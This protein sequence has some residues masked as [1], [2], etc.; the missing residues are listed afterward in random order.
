MLHYPYNYPDRSCEFKLVGLGVQAFLGVSPEETYSTPGVR[1]LSIKARGCIFKNE[2][3]PR[4][5][6]TMKNNYTWVKYSYLNCL[7]ECRANTVVEKCGCVP[8]YVPQTC[9]LIFL[10][11]YF[12][13][14]SCRLRF[15]CDLI[16]SAVRE[17]NLRDLKCMT[18]IRCKFA[19]AK[20][21]Y[22]V[23][24]CLF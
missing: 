7:N 8:F 21:D 24:E 13:G 16:V 11:E 20:E 18:E 14:R 17:C 2:K 10:R 12:G 6:D 23:F 5:L 22:I 1:D 19:F 3:I 4:S 9:R 15:E